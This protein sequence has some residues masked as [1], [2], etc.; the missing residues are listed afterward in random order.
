MS[1]RIVNPDPIVGGHV[2]ADETGA[3]SF[4]LPLD[5]WLPVRELAM[6]LSQSIKRFI[7][8]RKHIATV[9][10]GTVISSTHDDVKSS[11]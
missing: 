8:L 2:L 1:V 4:S 10:I 7:H 9:G 6:C 5:L 11:M 3:K